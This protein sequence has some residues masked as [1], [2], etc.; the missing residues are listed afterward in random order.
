MRRRRRSPFLRRSARRFRFVIVRSTCD[1]AIQS[2]AAACW[3]ASRSLSSGA[4]FAR[5]VGS[6]WPPATGEDEISLLA[7]RAPEGRAPVLGESPDDAATPRGLAFFAFAVVD[8]KRM[9]EVTEF[10]RGLAMV[11]QRRAAGLNRLVQY[12]M[13]R[14]DQALRMIRRFAFLCRQG[15]R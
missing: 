10:A 8:L 14:I 13:N 4:P 3:I 6:R 1:E 15:R 9:L 12:C 2:A 11:A 5:P 7:F